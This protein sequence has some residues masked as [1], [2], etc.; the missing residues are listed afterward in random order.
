MMTNA[1]SVSKSQ[2]YQ[3]LSYQSLYS[4]GSQIWSQWLILKLFLLPGLRRGDQTPSLPSFNASHWLW[5]NQLPSKTSIR[6]GSVKCS[7]LTTKWRIEQ[8]MSPNRALLKLSWIFIHKACQTLKEYIMS[9]SLS[10]FAFYSLSSIYGGF[11]NISS[12]SSPVLAGILTYIS[13][14]PTT[15]LSQ[16]L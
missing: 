11:L 2:F 15:I 10:V 5:R 1:R 8:L 14:S 9:V 13:K 16:M 7:P 12:L 3:F 4:R 6:K